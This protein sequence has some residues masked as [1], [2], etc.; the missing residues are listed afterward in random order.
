MKLGYRDGLK[1]LQVL[2]L[3]T[4]SLNAA[5][6]SNAMVSCSNNIR[7]WSL[8]NYILHIIPQNPK[9]Q[10]PSPKLLR[11]KTEFKD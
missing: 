1:F 7:V 3:T 6:K 8:F 4:E 11:S 9:P 5:S 10:T 2:G